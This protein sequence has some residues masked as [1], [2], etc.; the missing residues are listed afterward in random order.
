MKLGIISYGF[1]KE[2]F[3]KVA[4]MKLDFVEFC[5]NAGAYDSHE[6]FANR[7]DEI[8]GNLDSLGLF[9]GSVGRWGGDKLLPDGSVR[10][11]E[12]EADKKL[13][14]AAEQLG[15]PVYVTGCNYA[16]G[17]SLY[18]N[19]SAAIRYFEELIAFGKEHHV[20]IARW[21]NFVH[22]DPAWSVIH[23]Y[24]K[25]LGIK[26]DPSHSRYA[27][28]E[29]YLSEIK[30]WGT[31]FSHVHIKGSLLVNGERVDDPPAGLDQTDWPAFMG[32]LYACG[33]DGTLS[34][35]PHSGIWQGE[36]G[37][38]GVAYTIRMMRNMMLESE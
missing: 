10:T 7:A 19:Y 24:L 23:G 12:M 1:E 28:G 29:D 11:A 9:T 14:C 26:Y 37:Q 34:I 38:K 35:E 31:R 8:R 3:Q 27:M 2:D 22:S 17:I 15:C 21:S 30:K 18:E 25:E 5:V 6:A 13:I 16:D 4:D 33:Y 32:A 36:L 20:R